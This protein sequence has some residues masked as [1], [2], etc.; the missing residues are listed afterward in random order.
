VPAVATKA[1]DDATTVE[2]VTMSRFAE[3][4]VLGFLIG[5]MLVV[6][7]KADFQDPHSDSIP[8]RYKN[9]RL[10]FWDL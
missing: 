10:G 8:S 6:S 9:E 3:W 4:V 7:L 5:L 2:K 1:P